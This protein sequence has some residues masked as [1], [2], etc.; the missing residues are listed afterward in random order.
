M[1]LFYAVVE[2]VFFFVVLFVVF[3][4]VEVAFLRGVIFFFREVVVFAVFV[5]LAISGG[6]I[7]TVSSVLAVK[8]GPVVVSGAG[9]A[10][11]SGVVTLSVVVGVVSIVSS[12]WVAKNRALG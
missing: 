8:V 2:V 12:S 6:A 5:G 11:T 10:V 9:S 1:G 3:R 7:V 4:V